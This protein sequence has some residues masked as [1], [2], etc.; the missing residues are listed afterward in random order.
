M[1]L[2]LEY[3][4]KYRQTERLRTQRSLEL[5]E[6]AIDESHLEVISRKD[7]PH[8]PYIYVK[9]PNGD[10]SFNGIRIFANNEIISFRPQK[11]VDTQPYGGSYNLDLQQMLE[12]I[13][14]N[15]KERDKN[16]LA[17]MLIKLLGTILRQFFTKSIRAEQEFNSSMTSM[18]PKNVLG[19]IVIK[20]N[21]ND[22]VAMKNNGTDYSNTVFSKSN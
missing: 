19:N 1:G 9:N 11:D 18:M 2:F 12:D 22:A 14:N 16:K 10:L 8:Q 6:K 4:H 17:E 5:I 21:D 20:N 13:L 3:I 7:D 15:S